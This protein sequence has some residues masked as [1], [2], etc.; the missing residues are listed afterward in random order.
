MFN[1]NGKIR[2]QISKTHNNF[3][4]NNELHLVLVSIV[5]IN[6]NYIPKTLH[7]DYHCT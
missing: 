5:Y 3:M 1:H 7:N 2:N 4:N 6:V